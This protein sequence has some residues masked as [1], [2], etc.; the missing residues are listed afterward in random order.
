MVGYSS[1]LDT[2]LHCHPVLT[3]CINNLLMSVV[4]IEELRDYILEQI[5]DLPGEEQRDILSELAGDLQVMA[6]G[7]GI[8]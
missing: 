8:D 3:C 4:M 2:F 5:K 6:E 7:Y 1:A